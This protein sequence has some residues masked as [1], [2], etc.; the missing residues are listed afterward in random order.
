MTLSIMAEC[1]LLSVFMLNVKNNP[2]MLSY[3]M[4]NVVNLSVMVTRRSTVLILPLQ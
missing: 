3:V 2:F 4:L 1:F